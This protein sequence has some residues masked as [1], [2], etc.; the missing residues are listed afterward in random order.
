MKTKN[1]INKKKKEIS[2]IRMDNLVHYVFLEIKS[3]S[4][5]K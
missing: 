1:L 4:N 2:I 3:Y 5:S